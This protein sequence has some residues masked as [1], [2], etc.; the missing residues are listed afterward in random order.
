[1]NKL[2]FI[3]EQLGVISVPYAFMEWT[4]KDKSLY[5]TGEIIEE[6]VTVESGLEESTMILNGFARGDFLSL[7][8]EKEKIKA[9]FHPIHGLHGQTD[10]G[11][12][13]VFFDGAFYVPTGEA[14]F[15]RIQ[16]NLKIKEW[17][18]K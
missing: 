6:P 9:H 13:V 1:M 3:D 12:I 17:K 15:K 5:F 2:G 10:S 16:I 18:V 14:D 11:A 8:T 4:K 7:E